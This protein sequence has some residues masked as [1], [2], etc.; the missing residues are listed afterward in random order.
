MSGKNEMSTVTTGSAEPV[1]FGLD[2]HG[3]QKYLFATSKLREIVG[4]SR[5]VASLTDA[6]VEEALEA[7]RIR[8][9][10]HG[11]GG[12]DWFV[13][14]RLGGGSVRL[15]LARA[16]LAKVLAGT[17]RRRAIAEAP[18]LAFDMAMTPF[19]TSTGDLAEANGR[20]IERINASRN[21][22]R[23]GGQFAG[24]PFGAPCRL[25]FQPAGGYGEDVNERLCEASLAKRAAQRLGRG[26]WAELVRDHQLI[27]G[28]ATGDDPF[29]SEL[30]RMV[31]GGT[32]GGHVAVVC[33][34]LNDLGEQ[35]RVVTE[36]CRGFQAADAFHR[37]TERVKHATTK[38]F[39]AG[40]DAVAKHPAAA[41][42]LPSPDDAGRSEIPPLPLRPL[43]MGGD[44]LTF[45]MHGRLAVPFLAG[46]LRSFETD[47]FN[48][49]GGIAFVKA[50]S[51]FGRAVDVAEQLVASA[52][53][54]GRDRS[55]VDFL[56]CTDEI[57][58]D[59]QTMRTHGAGRGLR[60]T[61]GPWTLAGFDALVGKAATLARLPRRH[62]RAAADRCR[63]GE[64]ESLR[65]FED[66]RENLARGLGGR[67][68]ADGGGRFG[69]DDLERL[70]PTGF[71]REDGEEKSTDLLDCIDL[72]RFVSAAVRPENATH[73]P[74]P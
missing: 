14:V 44:D 60:L 13:P 72:F 58:S 49:G 61:A 18:G 19:D 9:R 53:R 27:S 41:T 23:G 39:R 47:G 10:G 51:P 54:K 25:T 30:S 22:V 28:R 6:W 59:V 48:G 69:V 31:D 4:A 5:L 52:K 17:L 63:E 45:V 70:Y 57:P 64:A 33:L 8:S 42:V 2:A 24:F 38:A 65:A 66:L 46:M 21:R 20:V 55:H 34:D 12:A 37:F 36:R 73:L 74:V 67:P 50:K 7:L 35:G 15:V 68:D 11:D 71:F 62:V 1:L 56:L 32:D 29:E 43:V 40:L 3:I 16:E 26:E